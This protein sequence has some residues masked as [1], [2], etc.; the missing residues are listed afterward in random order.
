MFSIH[1]DPSTCTELG[2]VDRCCD[3]K[4]SMGMCNVESNGVTCSCESSCFMN[5]NCCPDIGCRRMFTVSKLTPLVFR[6]LMKG[7]PILIAKIL[8]CPCLNYM[9][10]SYSRVGRVG[11]ESIFLVIKLSACK[12]KFITTEESLHRDYLCMMP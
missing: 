6:Y 2:F 5:N 1:A 7:F 9:P 4:L 10:Q 3:D 11:L 8:S 12:T